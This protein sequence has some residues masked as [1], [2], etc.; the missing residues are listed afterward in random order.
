VIQFGFLWLINALLFPLLIQEPTPTL[1]IWNWHWQRLQCE[2]LQKL[3]RNHM[4]WLGNQRRQYYQIRVEML[5][6]S[7]RIRE[8]WKMDQDWQTWQEKQSM[9]QERWSSKCVWGCIQRDKQTSKTTNHWVKAGKV[10]WQHT[11]WYG[12]SIYIYLYMVVCVVP[13]VLPTQSPRGIPL[14]WLSVTHSP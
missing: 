10:E 8:W 4:R 9:L 5:R 13:N 11:K 14:F 3:A 12:N 1:A 7:G 2:Y 6:G